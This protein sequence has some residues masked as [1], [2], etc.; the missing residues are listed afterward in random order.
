VR[1]GWDDGELRPC[2]Y[3][4]VY[5]IESRLIRRVR[6]DSP[7]RRSPKVKYPKG[8]ARRRGGIPEPRG[9]VPGEAIPV[10]LTE[11]IY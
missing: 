5:S 3:I 11:C 4:Y 10:Y 8:P 6:Y 1:V 7:P 9:A 2:H